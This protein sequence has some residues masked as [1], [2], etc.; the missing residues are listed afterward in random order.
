MLPEVKAYVR[1]ES[2]KLIGHPSR[3]L[4]ITACVAVSKLVQADYPEEWPEA[5]DHLLTLFTSAMKEKSNEAGLCLMHGCLQVLKDFIDES[6]TEE[7]FLQA[8]APFL[9]N[10]ISILQNSTYPMQLRASVVCVFRSCLE[11]LDALKETA[12]YAVKFFVDNILPRWLLTLVEVL[13]GMPKQFD[14]DAVQMAYEIV[15]TIERLRSIFPP[16]F[17]QALVSTAPAIYSCL[18]AAVR[19]YA[20]GIEVEENHDSGLSNLNLVGEKVDDGIAGVI[21][22]C[23]DFVLTACDNRFFQADLEGGGG[24]TGVST[25]VLLDTTIAVAMLTDAQVENAEANSNFLAQAQ[26]DTNLLKSRNQSSDVAKR[27]FELQQDNVISHLWQCSIQFATVMQ[28]WRL[29]ESSLFLMG[30]IA[31]GQPLVLPNEEI[32]IVLRV[33]FDGQFGL[34]SARTLVWASHYIRSLS[35]SQVQMCLELTISHLRHSKGTVLAFEAVSILCD[36]IPHENLHEFQDQVLTVLTTYPHS[37]I[38]DE[39]NYCLIQALVKAI[40]I[41]Y[42]VCLNEK[43]N[44]IPLL[45]TYASRSPSDILQSELIINAFRDIVANIADIDSS[46]IPYCLPPLLHVLEQSM[47]VTDE[48]NFA[49]KTVCFNFRILQC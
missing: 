8:G 30:G 4:R 28:N 40:T 32:E 14:S 19:Q 46:F 6:L 37:D 31:A 17:W 29:L 9:D 25:L 7:Q 48:Q 15:R 44:L 23:L 2:L 41:D 27:L 33:G 36:E 42:K 13:K 11:S 18:L 45:L 49:L 35:T 1:A 10:L 47:Q 39:F 34:L 3:A 43:F 22:E 26:V 12:V 24:E 21:S 38:G 16:A 5:L 20:E